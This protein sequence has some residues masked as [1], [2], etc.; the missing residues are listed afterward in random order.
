MSKTVNKPWGAEQWLEVNENYVAKLLYIN[1]GARLSKQYHEK[2]TE[3]LFLLSGVVAFTLGDR[4]T[5]CEKPYTKWHIPPGTIHRMEGVTNCVL[6][7]VS[8]PEL[9]DVVRVEDDYNRVGDIIVA[10]SGGFDPVHPGHIRMFEAAKKLGTKLVVILNND[11]WLKAKKGYAFMDQEQRKEVIEALA[12]VDEVYITKHI[13]DKNG[14]MDM[15][16]CSDLEE[17]KPHIFANGGDRFE[18]NIPEVAT[19]Y[20][21]NIGMMFNIG[22]EKIASS[23]DLVKAVG[24][25][26]A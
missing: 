19:C 26:N 4:T 22:G 25:K 6:F 17:V 15:S 14:I 23:S 2:K 24:D 9:Y 1:D 12:C 20:K 18:D 16:V 11:N 21:C 13:P 10:V 8:T 3:T 7:E 5:I